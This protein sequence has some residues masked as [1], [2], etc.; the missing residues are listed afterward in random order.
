MAN[1]SDIDK[2]FRV[3]GIIKRDDIEFYNIDDVNKFNVFGIF[4]ENDHYV[5][6]PGAVAETVSEGVKRLH[7]HTA[8]GR[9]CFKTNSPCLAISV[10]YNEVCKFNM[11]PMSG[12]AG[13]DIYVMENG[14]QKYKNFIAPSHA[15]EDVFECSVDFEDNSEKEIVLNLPLYSGIDSL[16]IGLKKNASVSPFN[17]YTCDKRIVFYGSSITQGASASRPG[18][19]YTAVLSRKFGFD[20]TNLGFAGSA[21]GE[22]PIA[23]YI[24]N[25]DM[26]VFVYDYD[27]NAKTAEYLNKTHEK[28]FKKVREK[29]PEIPVIFMTRPNKTYPYAENF[30]VVLKTYENAKAAGDKNV[31]FVSGQEMLN[32]FDAEMALVD[33]IHPSD[34]GF[35]GMAQWVGKVFAEIL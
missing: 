17:P 15:V 10:K 34:V 3:G 12:A 32:S 1:I 31:Y 28:M 22:D 35:L 8:G 33:G 16:Y 20:Y 5:R 13:F 7:K 24:S 19:C 29:H 11:F 21:A 2:N 25:L 23:D 18:N 4:R 27:H 9:V 30:K 6:L 14:E 26:D